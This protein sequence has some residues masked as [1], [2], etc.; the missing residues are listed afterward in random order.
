[1]VYEFIN[2]NNNIYGYIISISYI[3][4]CDTYGI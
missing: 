3:D 2:W 4:S 1:M